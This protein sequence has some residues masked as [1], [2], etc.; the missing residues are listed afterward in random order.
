VLLGKRQ[1][2]IHFCQNFN[3]EGR[4]GFKSGY[5]HHL[6]DGLRCNKEKGISRRRY[7]GSLIR[8]VVRLAFESEFEKVIELGKKIQRET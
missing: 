3:Y 6:I 4:T 7:Y 2:L 8:E 5:L 1:V